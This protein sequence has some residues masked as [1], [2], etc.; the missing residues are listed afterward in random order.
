MARGGA[1]RRGAK[2]VFDD[3]TYSIARTDMNWIVEG[4]PEGKA[5]CQTLEYACEEVF[6]RQVSAGLVAQPAKN[7]LRGLLVEVREALRGLRDF[8]EELQRAVKTAV[9]L[10]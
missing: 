4:G 9:L 10:K 8:R 3:G 5:Y 2:K 7:E 1:T 6:R